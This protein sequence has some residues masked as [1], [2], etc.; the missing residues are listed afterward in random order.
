VHP[1]PIRLFSVQIV[2]A[3]CIQAN[4]PFVARVVLSKRVIPSFVRQAV[5]GIRIAG[6]GATAPYQ[7][8]AI[9]KAHAA[10]S[11]MTLQDRHQ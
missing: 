6:L 11:N 1:L 9:I 3:K 8:R 7:F 10:D 5:L 2:T 4:A